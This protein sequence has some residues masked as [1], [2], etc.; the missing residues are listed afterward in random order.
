MFFISKLKMYAIFI[1][2]GVLLAVVLYFKIGNMA[3]ARYKAN[4]NKARIKGFKKKK[5][6]RH[7]TEND[8]DDD[9]ISGILPRE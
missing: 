9:L 5:E 6:V 8:S 4:E 1:A 3:V 7:E 2:S